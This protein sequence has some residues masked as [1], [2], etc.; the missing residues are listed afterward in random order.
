MKRLIVLTIALLGVTFLNAQ[1]PE[2]PSPER[3]VN[4]FAG[5]LE[6]NETAGLEQ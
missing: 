4:D 2:R 6:Q 1:I 5:V 3:L